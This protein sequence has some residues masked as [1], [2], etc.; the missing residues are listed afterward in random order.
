MNPIITF[1]KE[2]YPIGSDAQ[3]MFAAMLALTHRYFDGKVCFGHV[4]YDV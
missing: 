3:Q 2:D 1:I 4:Q